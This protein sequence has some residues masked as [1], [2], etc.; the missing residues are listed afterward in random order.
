MFDEISR[1]GFFGC[2]CDMIHE[3]AIVRSLW[4]VNDGI[5]QTIMTMIMITIKLIIFSYY[6]L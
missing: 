3:G 2:G 1:A 5:L 4:R 6:L